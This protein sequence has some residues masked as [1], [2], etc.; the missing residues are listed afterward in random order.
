MGDTTVRTREDGMAEFELS[1]KTYRFPDSELTLP[2]RFTESTLVDDALRIRYE[3]L[4]AQE[5][6][7]ELPHYARE[8]CRREREAL[9][10]VWTRL[11]LLRDDILKPVIDAQRV[12]DAN[13]D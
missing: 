6:N 12:A 2:M 4:Q 8:A 3:Y 11:D 9:G 13:R 10:K 7:W 5:R 1:G